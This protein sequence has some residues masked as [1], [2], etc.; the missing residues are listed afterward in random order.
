M[1][2][3]ETVS[4]SELPDH[5]APDG[6]EIRELVVGA[7][8][9]LAH[10]LLRAGKTSSAVAH[11]TIE[12][13]WYV[14]QGRGEVWRRSSAGESVV[15]VK[16]GSSLR[17]PAGTAFQFRASP[18]GATRTGDRIDASM[19]RRERSRASQGLLVGH[20]GERGLVRRGRLPLQPA[21]R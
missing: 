3:L 7:N 5:L 11:R 8:G 15:A 4:L 6:S 10:C 1:R 9:S 18:D 14:V 12:E 17:I 13:L 20:L 21:G 16:E 19:A 2:A